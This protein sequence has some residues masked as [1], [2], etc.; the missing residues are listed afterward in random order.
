MAGNGFTGMWTVVSAKDGTV[1]ETGFTRMSFT[2]QVGEEYI[3]SV[4]D[5]QNNVFDHWEDGNKGRSKTIVM[6]EEGLAL[7]AYYRR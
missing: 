5:Y 4:G 1:L 2:G 3:V 6:P 7:K